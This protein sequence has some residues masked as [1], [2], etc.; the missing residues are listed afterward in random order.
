[1]GDL[2]IDTNALAPYIALQKKTLA[3]T[4][5]LEEIE[6]SIPS[7]ST[8][9]GTAVRIPPELMPDDQLA[10]EYFEIFFANI[11][12]Y[13][14]VISK[15]YFY[16]QWNNNRSLI[17]PLLLEA[18][19]ACAGKTSQDPAQGAQW[20]A[21][22]SKHEN[23]FMDV[24]RLST[25]QALL[26]LLKAREANTKRGYYYRSW[27]TLKTICSMAKDLELDEHYAAHQSGHMCP[28]AREC[29]VKTRIWQTIFVVE[30][31][32]GG[33]Q[34][35]YDMG[36]DVET[37]DCNSPQTPVGGDDEEYRV[38]RN[39]VYL[40]KVIRN[41]RSVM[42][43]YRRIKKDKDWNT[44]PQLTQL[45]PIFPRWLEELPAD[46]QIH[47]PPDGS[48][49]FLQNHLVGNVHCYHHLSILILHRPQLTASN[50]QDGS[51]KQHMSIC[52]RS[53]KALC[54]IQDAIYQ[55]YGID[56]FLFM[57]RGRKNSPIIINDN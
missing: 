33:A 7:A 5:A 14:P 55:T 37:I 2:K 29:L 26:I 20:L 17:S 27:M 39:F 30:C 41:V 51:W 36:V 53:A 23:Y 32:V 15:S 22:A 25:L 8:G 46:M 40:V 52:Y 10:T 31:M 34:G 47:Y 4:P 54:R 12:P 44:N 19:F 49:P 35:R 3:E 56:G 57:Q 18:I 50:F 13:V 1:M 43:V 24:P 21:L 28:D 45:N 9:P 38:S 42:D 11:H 16:Q 48:A 6:Y